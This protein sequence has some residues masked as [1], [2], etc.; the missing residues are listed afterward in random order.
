[1]DNNN[2]SPEQSPAEDAGFNPIDDFNVGLL[3]YIL[4]KSIVWI[5][6]LLI[7]SISVSL[8]YLRYT[9]RI[10]ETSAT[11]MMKKEKTTQI[12][13]IQK[14]MEESSDE[15]VKEIRLLKSRYFIERATRNLPLEIGY[16]KEGKTKFIYSDLYTSTPFEVRGSVL[17]PETYN[18]QIYV[19]FI[20]QSKAYVSFAINGKDY[21]V[22]ADTGKLIKNPYFS[23]SVHYTG[24]V[25]PDMLSEIY[26]FKFY[27]KN[28][29]IDD[30]LNKLD[31][32]T[33]D[34]KTKTLEIY[35]RDKNPVRA[36]EALESV[37]REFVVYDLERKRESFTNI[38][39]FIIGQID[40]FSYAFDKYQDSLTNLKIQEGYGGQSEE[41][42]KD[43][44]DKLGEF[45]TSFADYEHDISL[46]G[47]FETYLRENKSYTV[48]PS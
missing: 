10:Y 46:M 47:Q 28:D 38:L 25:T 48:I 12:L 43:I 16:F 44:R 15:I 4:N 2:I 34:T 23:I 32:Q 30:V 31:V 5:V 8:L 6:L 14:M 17:N 18:K 24:E 7:L 35:Y 39:A 27:N 40:T 21:E 42:L 20:D 9:P 22:V 41:Y 45:E 36:K 3:I 11:L 26:Y 33:V 13:G 1:M 29:V 19:K 37:A